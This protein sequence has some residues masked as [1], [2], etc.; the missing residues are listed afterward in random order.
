MKIELKVL[1]STNR[2]NKKMKKLLFGLIGI[3]ALISMSSCG[4]NS[5][6]KLD[7]QV[8]AQ[9]GE[10]E[11]QYQ[12][13]SDLIGNLVATV[14]GAANFEKETLT[15]VIE[16]RAK[17]NSIQVDPSKL[18]PE[19]LQKFQSSQGELSQALGRL[20]VVSEKYPELKANQNFLDLQAEIAGTENRVAV[21]RR[22]FNLAV[23]AYNTNIRTFPN[24][25]FSGMFGF[26]AKGTFTAEAG[27]NKAPKV[28][29]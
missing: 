18:T 16:A 14:K 8:K 13:R 3:F 1:N 26:S 27:S 28:E 22:D 11:N 20:M 24:N 21:A 7:E 19:T 10:V 2:K 6:V 25:M 29:F 15:Q 5:S 17:A 4:Y 9:W 12:R 23:Q